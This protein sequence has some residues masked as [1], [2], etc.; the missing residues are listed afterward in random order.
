LKTL[1]LKKRQS[2]SARATVKKPSLAAI[3]F[4]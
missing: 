4:A 3:A 2:L 1:D